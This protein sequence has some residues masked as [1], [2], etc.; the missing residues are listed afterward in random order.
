[1]PTLPAGVLRQTEIA[2]AVAEVERLLA[3]DVVRIRYEI[4]TD[5]QDEWA[6]YFRVVLQDEVFNIKGRLSQIRD[7]LKQELDHRVDFDALGLLRYHK[8]RSAS[9]QARVREEAWA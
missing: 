4:T 7:Q 2:Q 6:V 9:D 8:F 5:W 1:M 3:P